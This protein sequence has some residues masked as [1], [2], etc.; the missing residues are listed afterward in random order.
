[1]AVGVERVAT[2]AEFF[3]RAWRA[4]PAGTPIALTLARGGAP[5]YIQVLS[6]DRDDFL[7]K[8]SLQ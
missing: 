7:R 4:G 2:L 6:G 1:V 3:R 5:V 8:P